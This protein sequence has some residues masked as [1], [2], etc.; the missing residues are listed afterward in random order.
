MP[1]TRLALS[2]E[3]IFCALVSLFIAA[4]VVYTMRNFDSAVTSLL[5]L[6]VAASFTSNL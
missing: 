2:F 1:E 6:L 4:H 5:I 3:I